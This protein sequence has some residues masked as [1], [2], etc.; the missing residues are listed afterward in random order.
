LLDRPQAIPGKC[1]VCGAVDRPVVDT[2]WSIDYYGVVY[3][4]VFCLT[5]V[6][7]IIGMVDGKLLEA[8]EANSARQIED[9]IQKNDLKVITNEQYF[10]WV[11]LISRL[12]ADITIN[13]SISDVVSV[14]KSTQTEPTADE[15]VSRTI[16]QEFDFTFDERPTSIPASSSDGDVLFNLG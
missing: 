5:E 3:F 4:C 15:D 6:A 13:S 16:E 10:S 11:D 1:V 8:A 7:S 14:N 9:Y 2:T 12:H